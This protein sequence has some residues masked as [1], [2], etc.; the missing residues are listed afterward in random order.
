MCHPEFYE[1]KRCIARKPHVC[2]ETGRTI[3]PGE[4]YWRCTG[5]WEGDFSQFKQSEAAYHFARWV[6]GVR[7][8]GD[9]RRYDPE[10]CSPFGHIAADLHDD[11]YRE[12]WN[13][14]CAGVLTR[15]TLD[16]QDVPDNY[17]PLAGRA[18]EG[19]D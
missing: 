18:G 12:E 10:T 17:A 4:I 8:G 6:N 7:E 15:W 19:A 16:W 5:V 13:A 2:C 9:Y 1:E 14:V 3:R 11:S